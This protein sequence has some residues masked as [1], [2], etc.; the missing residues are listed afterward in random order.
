MA[1]EARSS[2]DYQHAKHCEYWFSFLHLI[3]DY[4]TV[5]FIPGTRCR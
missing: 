3:E 1:L 2:Q 5:I 4:V